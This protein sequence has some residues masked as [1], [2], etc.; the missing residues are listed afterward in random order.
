M[1][2]AVPSAVMQQLAELS[3]AAEIHADQRHGLALTDDGLARIDQILDREREQGDPGERESV[4]LCYGAWIG[5]HLVMRHHAVWVGLYEPVP[6][7]VRL[8]GVC[9]SPI[10]A[11][12]RRLVDPAAAS[13][14]Q[15]VSCTI[16][17]SHADVASETTINRSAWDHCAGDVRFAASDAGAPLDSAA[18]QAALDPWLMDID[19]R[20]LRLLCLA[21]AGGT[22]GPLYAQA[23]AQVTVVDF[24][25]ALLALDE[26]A[27]RRHRLPLTTIQADLRDLSVLDE[28]SFD[29]VLQPV[30]SCYIP[31]LQPMHAG[32]ARVLKPGGLYL[33]QHKSPASLQ[34]GRWQ[35]H[36]SPPRERGTDSHPNPT[37]ERGAYLLLHP[38]AEGYRLVPA[39]GSAAFPHRESEMVEYVHPLDSLLGGLCRNGFI[40]EDFQEPVRG[41]AWAPPE[42]AE[43]RAHFLPPYFKVLA[44]LQSVSSPT[45][46][47]RCGVLRPS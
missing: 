42:S 16:R 44:R 29:M 24:S 46:S 3:A 21:A 22:H 35:S 40:I 2:D 1:P 31:D 37:H 36:P 20:G 15:L 38:A 27:A 17:S 6:P 47:P 19:L 39:A 26:Q 7:R 45:F 4:A 32:V 9:Y 12:R 28:S 34:A 23:G 14:H 33:S 25:S 10:D 11:V 41:D 13:V 8:Q 30:S 5:Q 18:I 43:H